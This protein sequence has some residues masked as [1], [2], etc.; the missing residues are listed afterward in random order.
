MLQRDI[1]DRLGIR[2]EVVS[3]IETERA[4][5]LKTRGDYEALLD[6]LEKG[7]VQD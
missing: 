5:Y 2:T 6:E 4:K 1:A 3:S 7:V